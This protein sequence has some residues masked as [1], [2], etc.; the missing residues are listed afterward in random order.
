MKS[1]YEELNLLLSILLAFKKQGPK[2]F[3]AL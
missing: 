2:V 1:G 3:L